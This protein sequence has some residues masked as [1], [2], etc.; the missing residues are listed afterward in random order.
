MTKSVLVLHFFFL[1]FLLLCDQV[2]QLDLP[3]FTPLPIPI[4]LLLF[5][6][7]KF[8]ELLCFAPFS[9]LFLLYFFIIKEFLKQSKR[10]KWNGIKQRSGLKTYLLLAGNYKAVIGLLSTFLLSYFIHFGSLQR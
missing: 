1:L 7:E 3:L 2:I 6:Q 9:G 8:G 10:V 5:L 4:P